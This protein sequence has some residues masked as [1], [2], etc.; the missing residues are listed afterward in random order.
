M[1]VVDEC[2]LKV[3]SR[4]SSNE[5]QMSSDYP[6]DL[7]HTDDETL[8]DVPSIRTNEEIENDREFSIFTV[9]SMDSGILNSFERR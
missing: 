6:S 2:Q 1:S 3:R 5:A 4:N 7:S 8:R 9:D